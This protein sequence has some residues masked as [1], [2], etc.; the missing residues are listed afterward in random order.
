MDIGQVKGTNPKTDAEEIRKLTVEEPFCGLAFK[1]QSD[2]HVGRITYVRIYSGKLK[3]GSY[4]LNATKNENER[5]GRLLLMHANQR[6][7][8]EE[9]YAGEIV[10]VVG[11]KATKTGDTLCDDAHP[12]VLEGISFAEPVISLAIEPKTK[13]DQ[14]RMGM[15]LGKLSEE[16][17]TFRIKSNQETGQT[18]IAGMGELHLKSLLTA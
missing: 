3:S 12:I 14:E 10:A 8:I 1:I 18:I 4:T 11:L 16:D 15:A 13:S 7:E 9:A 5:V 17:P 6:E 2:P